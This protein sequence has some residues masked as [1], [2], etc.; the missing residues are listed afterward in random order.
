M[1]QAAAAL[2]VL[3][4]ASELPALRQF[5]GMYRAS[6]G[7]NEDIA[8]AVVNVARAMLEIGDRTAR[9]QIEAAAVDPTTV[10]YASEQLRVLLGGD[11][12]PSTLRDAAATPMSSAY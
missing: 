4:S 11:G 5:F 3:A 6:C 9:E 8:D 1:R 7:G 12:I 2:A 10:P